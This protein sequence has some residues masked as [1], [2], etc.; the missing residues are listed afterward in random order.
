MW[1]RET[2]W[3]FRYVPERLLTESDIG[4]TFY[5]KEK[6]NNSYGK[7]YLLTDDYV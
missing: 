3:K 5:G 1:K 4:F 7:Q 6:I 2:D